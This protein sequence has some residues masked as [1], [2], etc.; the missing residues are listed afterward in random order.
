MARRKKS[1]LLQRVEYAAYRVV[2][3]LVSAASDEGLLHWGAIFG[4]L[5]RRLLRGRDR[6]AMRN[7][8]AAFPERSASDL[9][10]VLDECWRHFGREMLLFVQM[11]SMTLEEIAARCPFENAGLLEQ[12][13][14]EGNGVVL[15][16]AHFGGWEVGGLALMALVENV[17]TVARPLDNEYLERDLA[18]LRART[19]AAVIDR[20]R[21][22]RALMKGL[23]ENATVVL[24]PDQAVQE[25]EGV[26]VPFIGRDAWTTPAPAKMA[27]RNDSAI[28]FAFCIPDGARHRLVFE[29]MIRVGDLDQEEREAVAL[30]R[31]I[32]DVIS[33]RIA[34]RPEWWLW[35]HDRWKGTGKA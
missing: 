28:V 13:A 5:S 1:V 25:R 19:G 2:S 10:A 7:L 30:T 3:R 12:A 31:R 26:L 16:S 21:A 11:Q 9:R 33:E 27:L 17:R 20:R 34:S 24:L 6:L 32:N 29:K 4:N 35:M 22:A 18:R 8:R 14:A 23:S 15:I